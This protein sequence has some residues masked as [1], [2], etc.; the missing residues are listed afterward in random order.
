MLRGIYSFS[1]MHSSKIYIFLYTIKS[2]LERYQ[3][4]MMMNYE[5]WI[6]RSES[7]PRKVGEKSYL[8]M[9][10]IDDK[11]NMY[12]STI[13]YLFDNRCV[14]ISSIASFLVWEGNSP[15]FTDR[16]KIH[17][18]VTYMLEQASERSILG[19]K[20]LLHLHTNTINAVPF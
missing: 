3:I 2:G 18:Y 5:T 10:F 4:M 17:V 1:Q 11:N 16:K 8:V 6:A 15:K 12:L 13:S 20:Y 7:E 14:T 9:C 19:F